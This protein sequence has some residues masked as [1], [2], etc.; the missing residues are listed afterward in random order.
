MKRIIFIVID[1]NART[2]IEGIFAAGDIVGR[3]RRIPEAI[4]EGGFAAIN[5][6][7]YM[8]NPYWA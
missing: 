1:N 7:K 5:A 2:N 3:W 4:G 6:F 8:K